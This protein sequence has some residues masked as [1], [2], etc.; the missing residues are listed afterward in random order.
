MLILIGSKAA[1]FHHP[2]IW[3]TSKDL[4]VICTYENFISFTQE[5]DIPSFPIGSNK[6]VGHWDGVIVEFEIAWPGSS[7]HNLFGMIEGSEHIFKGV[8][9]FVPSMDWLFAFKASHKYKKNC[10]HFEKTIR[11]YHKMQELGYTIPNKEWFAKREKETYT[12]KRPKLNTSKKN[13]FQDSEL[14]Y[15]YDHDTLHIAVAHLDQ[16]AYEYYKADNE[17]V[18]CSRKKWDACD[19]KIKLYGVLEESYVLALERSQI[20]FGD[21][22]LPYQSFK[23]ALMK[24]CTSITSGWFREYAYE[25]YFKLLEMYSGDYVDKFKKGLENGIV[26]KI[27]E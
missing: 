15:L 13:F 14:K 18:F 3:K 27:E 26:K 11:D 2:E 8:S 19:E 9:F 25:N 16:P 24:V 7:S 23:V 20:P 12:K 5:R 1:N 6:F 4:D 21:V 10:P 17:E 22:V